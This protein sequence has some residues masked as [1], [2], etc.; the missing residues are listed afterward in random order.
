M[1]ELRNFIT[2]LRDRAGVPYPLAHFQPLTSGRNLV[3]QAQEAS[4]LDPEYRLVLY[5]DKQYLLSYA[6]ERFMDQVVW[7][8]DVAA[9]WKPAGPASPVTVSPDVRFGRPAIRGVSTASLFEQSESGASMGELATDYGLSEADIRWA[10][11]YE[12]ERHAAA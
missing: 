4:N 10:L 1:L 2:D 5:V 11:A 6:G 9:G 8:D 3:V 12:N 7:R